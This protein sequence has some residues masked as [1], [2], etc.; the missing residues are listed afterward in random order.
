MYRHYLIPGFLGGKRIGF[1]ATGSL[2]STIPER[3]KALRAPFF[4]RIPVM[5]FSN[6]IIL[7]VLFLS[8]CLG[9]F[10]LVFL[11]AFLPAAHIGSAYP[12]LK[13]LQN[14]P[15]PGSPPS[16]ITTK[17]RL[18]YLLVRAGWPPLLWYSTCVGMWTPIWYM[19]FPPEALPGDELLV[20]D[21]RLKARY[22]TP[23]AMGSQLSGFG[24]LR[25]H[26]TAIVTVY[27]IV[28]FGISWYI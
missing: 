1:Q 15:V 7:H 17:V 21:E 11:R 23:A 16:A 8:A 9:G 20:L 12:L 19:L 6:Y 10:I 27:S 24:R 22:P 4:R 5:L 25:D 28:M 18:I 13:W 2:G 3:E 14:N 26:S